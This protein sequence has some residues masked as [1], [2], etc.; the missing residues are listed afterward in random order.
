MTTI[1]NQSRPA[2]VYD[3][4][5]DTWVPIGVGP[6]TH[7]EYIEKTV[8]T[9]KGDILVGTASDAVTKLGVGPEGSVL[10]VDPTSPTGLAWGEAGGSI[11]VSEDPPEDPTE[12]NVWFNA[13]EGTSYIYYDGFWVPLSP[14]VTGPRGEPGF[15]VSDSEPSDTGLLWLD[16]DEV[17]V[18]SIPAGGTS[19]QIL[20]KATNSDYDA[21]WLNPSS[22]NAIIN[23]AFDFWQRGTSFTNPASDTYVADR[24]KQFTGGTGA[25]R[26]FTREAFT[27]G[28]APVAGV[29]SQFF[30]RM[31]QTV[32]GTG[33]TFNQIHQSIEDVRT[34][35]GQT[36]TVS[37]YA[38]AAAA[39]TITPT[40][41]QIFGSGGSSS[42][43]TFGS[44]VSVTTSWQRF[45][46]TISL[47][48]VAGRTIGTNSRLGLAILVPNNATFTLDIWGVQ[49]EAGSVATPFRRAANTLQ[50]ELAAC[51]RYAVVYGGSSIYERVCM[52]ASPSTTVA[53]LTLATP[54][55]MRAIP[56]LSISSL[57]HFQ[58]VVLGV[59]GVTFSSIQIDTAES[60]KKALAI[61]GIFPTNASFGSSKAVAFAANNTLD[62]KLILSAEL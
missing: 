15:I 27:P 17:G 43:V 20:T 55:E 37:F 13:S 30:L 26:I 36:V 51:Q 12:G 1:G 31:N 58:V 60:G 44:G 25:T 21:Q 54:V 53:Y 46:R 32:A 50:G 34:F 9:A 16:S 57:S 33:D 40:L 38:K 52:G 24:F 49:V 62:A 14:A 29:E 22:A 48:S 56:T 59:G 61:S 19:G 5:T 28:V 42:V 47:P 10:I 35:A 3:S 18:E 39:I 4:E 2:Y 11:G 23:G 41:E 45:T 8:I 6:H 7:D